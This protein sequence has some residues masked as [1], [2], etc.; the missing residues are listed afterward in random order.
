MIDER[1]DNPKADGN[2]NSVDT[3]GLQLIDLSLSEPGCPSQ[4]LAFAPHSRRKK[5]LP[6][7]VEEGICATRIGSDQIPMNERLILVQHTHDNVNSRLARNALGASAAITTTHARPF[8][9]S[10][11]WLKDEPVANV[12]TVNFTG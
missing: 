10:H 7:L 1:F 3:S 4:D 11:P 8:V 9:F 12:Y 6:M 2:P 5:V